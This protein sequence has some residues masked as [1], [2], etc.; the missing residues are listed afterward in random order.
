MR[1]RFTL[2][3]KSLGYVPEAHIYQYP[4]SF[5]TSMH[6][7]PHFCCRTS[8]GFGKIMAWWSCELPRSH[9]ITK[10]SRSYISLHP[11]DSKG[12]YSLF[13]GSQ[14]WIICGKKI[15]QVSFDQTTA[16]QIRRVGQHHSIKFKP[17]SLNGFK[18][19]SQ[20]GLN[21][22]K[23]TFK[24]IIKH[25]CFGQNDASQV[26]FPKPNRL[27]RRLRW[28]PK[29]VQLQDLQARR[30]KRLGGLH[31]ELFIANHGVF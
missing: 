2:Y 17:F 4:V 7:D 14:N 28:S 15:L 27:S 26:V 21:M 22:I 8:L 3:T 23:N 12:N 1:T 25:Y 18:A 16:G 11:K 19:V 31:A 30:F 29:E 10:H 24:H 6:S 13:K 5:A 20:Y 9:S